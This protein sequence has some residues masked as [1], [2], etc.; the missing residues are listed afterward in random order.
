MKWE[1]LLM[2]YRTVE[3]PNGTYTLTDPELAKIAAVF[4]NNLARVFEQY[5]KDPSTGKSALT[6]NVTLHPVQDRMVLSTLD[7]TGV[8][9]PDR[10]VTRSEYE[11]YAWGRFDTVMVVAPYRGKIVNGRERNVAMGVYD[12]DGVR[13]GAYA[14]LPASWDLAKCN[15]DFI[16]HEFLHGAAQ[17]YRRHGFEMPRDSATNVGDGV[18]GRAYNGY[19]EDANQ[20]VNPFHEDFMRGRIGPRKDLGIPLSAWE[21]GVPR[22][23]EKFVGLGADDPAAFQAVYAELGFAWPRP[24]DP[25]NPDSRAAKVDGGY[26]QYFGSLHGDCAILKGPQGTFTVRPVIFKGFEEAGGAARMG[27]PYNAVHEWEG[28]LIQDFIKGDSRSAVVKS[29]GVRAYAI[30]PEIFGHYLAGGGARVLGHPINPLHDWEGGKIQGFKKAGVESVVLQMKGLGTHLV[31]PQIWNAYRAAGGPA[32]MGFPYNTLHDWEGVQ[33][34][35][36]RKGDSNCAVM[37]GKDMDAIAV[38]PEI[39][40]HYLTGGGAKVLGHPIT[41]LHDWEGGK[42]QN[43]MKAGVESAV[44]QMKDLGT[45]PV[46]PQIWKAYTAAGGPAVM[47][48]PYNALHDW[49]GVKLQDFRKGN[50]TSAVALGSGGRAYAIL[51]EVWGYYLGAGGAPVLGHPTTSLEERDGG[52]V[53]EFRKGNATTAVMKGS[54]G[55]FVVQPKVWFAVSTM[56]GTAAYGYPTGELRTLG[57]GKTQIFRTSSGW[58]TGAMLADGTN[59]VFLVKGVIWKHYQKLGGAL[60]YLGYPVAN[61]HSVTAGRD[62]YWKQAFQ[63]GTI[64]VSQKTEVAEDYR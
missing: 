34:Q 12:P 29:K 58:Q 36:F 32:V 51:P 1:V 33:V 11:K 47:G 64:R 37:Q 19:L 50:T 35:D 26:Q 46:L 55:T 61:E 41:P 4:Q 31:L 9:W 2:R 60:S 10:D 14:A 44:M 13:G 25:N 59:E 22:K 63:G 53:Q 49:E 52:K 23:P 8:Y 16:V 27:F 42:I 20:C 28:V 40:G 48:Y 5:T 30:L 62:S 54:S 17:F 15:L 38:V 18:H 21:Q 39:F 3:D 6:A 24:Q 57:K 7:S 43:F 45:H 56:G